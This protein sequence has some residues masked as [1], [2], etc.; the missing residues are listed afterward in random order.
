MGAGPNL[1]SVVT[2]AAL[3][4]VAYAR[5]I[6]LEERMLIDALGGPDV[7]YRRHTWRLVPF[8]F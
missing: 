1:L 8:V 4:A 6:R 5:R 2:V 3:L 7:E